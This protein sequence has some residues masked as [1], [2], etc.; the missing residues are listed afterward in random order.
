[1]MLLPTSELSVNM[2]SLIDIIS[3]GVE[4]VSEVYK[5]KGYQDRAILVDKENHVNDDELDIYRVLAIKKLG[6]E[7]TFITDDKDDMNLFIKKYL[8]ATSKFPTSLDLI[9]NLKDI[10][11]SDNCILLALKG[12]HG[13]GCYNYAFKLIGSEKDCETYIRNIAM[14]MEPSKYADCVEDFDDFDLVI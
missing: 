7:Y 3:S 2:L 12:V 4:K 10:A 5:K 14:A 11:I 9:N 8:I 6:W 13:P 1:M